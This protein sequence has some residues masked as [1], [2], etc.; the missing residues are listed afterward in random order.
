MGWDPPQGLILAKDLKD[1]PGTEAAVESY[2]FMQPDG[3][4]KYLGDL[5]AEAWLN[6]FPNH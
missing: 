4:E 5:K 2:R 3:T 6:S 1:T